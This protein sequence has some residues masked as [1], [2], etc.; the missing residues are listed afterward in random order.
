MELHAVSRMVAGRPLVL[1]HS[2]VLKLRALSWLGKSVWGQTQALF[3][4]VR[5]VGGMNKQSS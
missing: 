5:G 1:K 4:F 3:L 2:D